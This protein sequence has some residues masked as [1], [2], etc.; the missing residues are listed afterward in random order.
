MATKLETVWKCHE[1]GEIHDD[2]DSTYEC[3]RPDVS[4]GYLCPEC[5][6]FHRS[7]AN[8]LACCEHDPDAPPPPPTAAELEAAGQ[9]RMVP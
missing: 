2:E 3:C 1:C 6:D 4:E 5:A 9:L 8:A 7:E